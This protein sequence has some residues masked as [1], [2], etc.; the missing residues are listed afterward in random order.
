MATAQVIKSTAL[1]RPPSPSPFT[2]AQ[3][4][5]LLAVADAVI[6][7]LQ[8]ADLSSCSS[9]SS[10]SSSSS[11]H[12]ADV[13]DLVRRKLQDYADDTVL[14]SYLNERASTVPGFEDALLRYL[15]THT[16]KPFRTSGAVWVPK[17]LSSATWA[18]IPRQTC[19]RAWP[20]SLASLSMLSLFRRW[21]L[22]F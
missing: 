4:H 20:A 17:M 21:F 6:A 2:P 5:V 9:S 7:P 12:D 14:T 10:A 3:W 19:E 11:S 8:P 1:P 13:Y 18:P 15:G 22:L 16:A